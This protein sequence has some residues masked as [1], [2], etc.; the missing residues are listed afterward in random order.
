MNIKTSK[1]IKHLII[2]IILFG[3]GISF[4]LPLFWM[5]RSSFMEIGQIFII[6]PE[7]IPKP[8]T[9]GNFA[10][11]VT[12]APFGL[13]ALNTTII[14]ISG[15]FGTIL[16]ATLAAFGF[17]RLK[18][19]GRDMIFVIILSSMMLPGAVT[20]I[21]QFIGWNTLGFYNTLMPLIFPSFLG[22]GAFNI[23]L[24]RQFFMTIPLELDEAAFVDGASYLTIYYKVILPL[25]KSALIVVAMFSFMYH[26]N[27]FFNPLIYL[28]DQAKFT[29][30]IGLQQLQGQYVSAWHVIMAASTIVI[31]PCILVF[32]LGQKFI[33]EGIVMTGIKA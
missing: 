8:F 31:M 10:E 16:T 30:A 21:P 15:T 5:I 26:W 28:S 11:A 1:Q 7:W 27:D 12:M 19:K 32:L 18:W 17:S 25:S 6:P 22:G 14:L 3:L 4:V 13:Y 9:L 33:L 29:L 23:F 20:L 24:L 2:Y